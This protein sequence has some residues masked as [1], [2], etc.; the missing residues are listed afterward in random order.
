ML[1]RRDL[2]AGTAATVPGTA[3]QLQ[4]SGASANGKPNILVIAADDLGCTDLGCYGASDLKTP[5]LDAL[6]ASGVQWTNWYSNAP[7]CAP[8][9]GSIMTGRYPQRHGVVQNGRELDPSKQKTLAALLKP[10]GYATA[11]IGKWHL[12]RSPE[13][14]PNARG[15]DYF[16]GF[17]SG[18]VDFYSHRYYW[19]EPRSV[20]CH[21]LWRNREE[22]FE[23]GQYL[24][25]RIAQES[26]QFIEAHRAQ[27]F[28]LYAAFNAVHY[29]M[30]VPRSYLSRFS[31]L[32][33][34]RQMYAA[35]LA[36]A[37][38]G[39]GQILR[40]LNRIGQRE[41]TLIY[42]LGDNGATTEPRAGLN[43]QPAT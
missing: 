12:G 1:S 13:T 32:G 11:L 43:Q 42:V 33:R 26:S 14:V 6:A 15:F 34:E 39:V 17:H 29:P 19:G 7:V 23:D 22:V 16:Y 35:M 10:N 40:S 2:L 9:R 24:T 28:F 18:C 27:P 37:D 21:D 20:N 4:Q 31:G 38:D 41:N 36:A 3:F 5:N 30:H 25:E 8:A